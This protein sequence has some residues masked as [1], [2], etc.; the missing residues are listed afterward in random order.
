MH[1]ISILAIILPDAS[2]SNFCITVVS[3]KYDHI[4]LL[5]KLWPH[6]EIECL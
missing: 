6:K 4:K 5:D 1:Y 3:K 2:N